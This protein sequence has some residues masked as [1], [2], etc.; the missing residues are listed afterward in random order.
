[1]P[2][3]RIMNWNIEQLSTAKINMGNMAAVIA[4]LVFDQNIDIFIIVE[5]KDSPSIVLNALSNA[6][7]A[8]AGGN[9]YRGWFYS[10][11]TGGDYY[12][13]IIRDM[14]LIRPLIA[15]PP[16]G[17]PTGTSA[18]PLSNLG[19]AG[20]INQCPWLVWPNDFGVAPIP[21]PAA[22]QIMP[23]TDVYA[24]TPPAGG[25][26][27]HFA[28][29]RI[30][31]GG[32]ALGTGF[33]LPCL[34]IFKIYIPA[35]VGVPAHAYHIPT[36]SCHYAAVRSAATRNHLAQGQI[37][38]LKDLHIAQLFNDIQNPPLPAPANC[39]RIEINGINEPV[40][41]ILFVGDYNVNFLQN[42]PFGT[43]IERTNHAAYN[44]LTFT[45]ENG[46]STGIFPF[47]NIPLPPA[48]PIAG[49]GYLM[50]INPTPLLIRTRIGNQTLMAAVTTQGT[51]LHHF[52]P[53]APLPPNT[54][55]LRGAAFDNFIYSGAQLGTA[56]MP[57]LAI[58]V[59]PAP[60]AIVT[61]SAYVVD[62]PAAILQPGGAAPPLAN[63]IIVDFVALAY[64]LA[65]TKNAA[66]APRLRLPLAA[67][68]LNTNDRL[69]G[70]R[71]ISDHLPVVLEFT[72]P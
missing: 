14:N 8:L 44:S 55:A 51:I 16:A 38:Q 9:L 47:A 61:N 35:A 71:L 45:L 3:I 5:L 24:T 19:P 20:G 2:Q 4:Q 27:A 50:S 69:I 43:A 48:L 12:G 58:P 25:H 30:G 46:N 70:A 18:D 17:A 22:R 57:N 66:A 62:V 28:G 13:Y 10:H 1:M 6:L 67:G 65:G 64:F 36:I 60:P 33:R 41:N 26:R 7:N 11:P 42:T 72:C 56:T 39:H 15:N 68:A 29:Q 21:L 59:P 34:A 54:F 31:A 53:A 23:L 40:K 52:D 32:Y 63:Q 37:S 49:P